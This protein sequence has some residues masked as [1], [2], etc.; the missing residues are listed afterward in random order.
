M[1]IIMALALLEG[2]V[3]LHVTRGDDCSD[4]ANCRCKYRI[5]HI[6]NGQDLVRVKYGP[7]ST[8]NFEV[9]CCLNLK[10]WMKNKSF[11]LEI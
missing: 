9:F 3:V 11:S 4:P 8:T 6:T 2:G 10:N 1:A 7:N 5:W